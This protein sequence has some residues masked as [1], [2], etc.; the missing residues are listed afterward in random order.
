MNGNNFMGGCTKGH[1]E[2]ADWKRQNTN[3][4]SPLIQ[5]HYADRP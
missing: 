2:G 1:E 5:S 3:V 4:C